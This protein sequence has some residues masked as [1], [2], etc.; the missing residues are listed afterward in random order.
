[1]AQRGE[2]EQR[3]HRRQTGVASAGTV[4]PVHFQMVEEPPDQGGVEIFDAQRC[5]CLAR[6]ALHELEQEAEGV[7]ISSDGVGA[8]T[9]LVGQALGEKSL[10]RGGEGS[11]GRLVVAASRRA[12]ARAR[13]S[14]AAD[15]YQ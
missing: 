2:A 14:G 15:K 12:A 8:G 10:E 3:T 7:P 1:M 4:V 11:H 5:R 13:S 6:L 9:T